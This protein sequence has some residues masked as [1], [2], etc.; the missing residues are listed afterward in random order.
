MRAF[1]PGL[2]L[3]VLLGLCGLHPVLEVRGVQVPTVEECL[4]CSGCRDPVTD[5]SMLSFLFVMH[6]A[7]KHTFTICN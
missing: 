2:W 6:V 3:L 7:Q 5:V 1:I 4:V